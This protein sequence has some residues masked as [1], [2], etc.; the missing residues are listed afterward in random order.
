MLGPLGGAATQAPRASRLTSA[1]MRSPYVMP[2]LYASPTTPSLNARLGK[3]GRAA[4]EIGGTPPR[5][6]PWRHRSRRPAPPGLFP[7]LDRS[8]SDRQRATTAE[9]RRT[10][11]AGAILKIGRR[12]AGDTGGLERPADQGL[13]RAPLP[14]CGGA[15]RLDGRE[16]QAEPEE[17]NARLPPG[18]FWRSSLMQFYS[19][20]PMHLLPGVDTETINGLYKAEVIHRR[21][22]W[23]RVEDVELATLRWVSWFNTRQLLEPSRCRAGQDR[24]G[25]VPAGDGRA[26]VHHRPGS[27]AA[28]VELK[29][30]Q[31]SSSRRGSVL[32][33]VRS[34]P[35]A[36]AP[37]RE[38]AA[39]RACVAPVARRVA[40]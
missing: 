15:N 38:R 25:R 24:R 11:T 19:G 17:R 37:A 31:R 16:M 28:D 33:A 23:H 13:W 14:R 10:F 12:E 6:A 30:A 5:C 21:S 2:R 8:G 22:S 7:A 26:A 36:V 34:L 4:A 35:L 32:V 3:T 39:G 18:T 1:P 20:L 9:D 29:A 27:G 40:R